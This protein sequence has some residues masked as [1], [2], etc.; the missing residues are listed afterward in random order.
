VPTNGRMV[1]GCCKQWNVPR[2]RSLARSYTARRHERRPHR[3]ARKGAIGFSATDIAREL[4]FTCLPI[5]APHGAIPHVTES[6]AITR[7]VGRVDLLELALDHRRGARSRSQ[8][9]ASVAAS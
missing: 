3:L 1:P 8:T 9:A 7:I 6:I 2:H 4:A 5:H